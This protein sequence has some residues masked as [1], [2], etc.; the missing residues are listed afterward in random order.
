VL[1]LLHGRRPRHKTFPSAACGRAAW[2]VPPCR[3]G[4]LP[5]FPQACRERPW[6]AAD[7]DAATTATSWQPAVAAPM[8]LHGADGGCAFRLD[9]ELGRLEFEVHPHMAL[10]HQLVR[11]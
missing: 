5:C 1:L 2:R 10:E 4:A 7:Q 8:R 11:R 9:V 3:C 6:R